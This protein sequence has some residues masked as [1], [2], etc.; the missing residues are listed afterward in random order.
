MAIKAE[1]WIAI[2]P[3]SRLTSQTIICMRLDAMDFL[4]IRDG[5]RVFACERACPHEQADLSLGR[6]ADG[7]FSSC[8]VLLCPAL[9]PSAAAKSEERDRSSI[10]A[11]QTHPRPS[12]SRP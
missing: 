11:T 10:A 2:C 6:V 3:S 4:L 12:C 5:D 7:R 1:N 8:D 9:L